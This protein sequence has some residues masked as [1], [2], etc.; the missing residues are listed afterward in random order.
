MKSQFLFTFQLQSTNPKELRTKNTNKI[1]IFLY[2]L[3]KDVGNICI[4]NILT[5]KF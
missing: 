4:K 2:N 3:M 1:I 5:F